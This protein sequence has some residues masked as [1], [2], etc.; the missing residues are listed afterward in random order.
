MIR[1]AKWLLPALD[2]QRR[3]VVLLLVQVTN[4]LF[5]LHPLA[6][7]GMARVG[8]P[9]SRGDYRCATCTAHLGAFLFFISMMFFATAFDQERSTRNKHLEFSLDEYKQLNQTVIYDLWMGRRRAQTPYLLGELCASLGWM[10]LLPSTGALGQVAGGE[11][12]RSAVRFMYAAFQGAAMV[13]VI[14]FTFQAGLH[15]TT[16]WISSW[17]LMHPDERHVPD[18]TPNVSVIVSVSTNATTLAG[19]TDESEDHCAVACPA[20]VCD[21]DATA[22]APFVTP[23]CANCT[24]CRYIEEQMKRMFSSFHGISKHEHND[25]SSYHV[26]L[27]WHHSDAEF[28]ALQALELDYLISGSRTLWLFALDELLL[29]AGWSTAAFL[30]YTTSQLSDNWGHLSVFGAGTAFF[31]F[32]F[33]VLRLAAWNVRAVLPPHPTPH[34]PLLPT[35]A[36]PAHLCL[37]VSAAVCDGRLRLRRLH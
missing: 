14:D 29:T 31:G 13:S 17:P 7:G 3:Y 36:A 24:S 11:T 15:T 37:L 4:P 19:R 22:G 20:G 34:G 16:D 23:E 18:T 10:S 25:E 8:E 27:E 5:R 35:I 21:S 28:G 6:N 30:A 1:R 2:T 33:S 12:G 9:D 32:I 26:E